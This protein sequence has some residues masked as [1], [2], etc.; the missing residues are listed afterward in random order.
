MNFYLDWTC[1]DF[2]LH[3]IDIGLCSRAY[4][5]R[6]SPFVCK[7]LAVVL[8][9]NK[10]GKISLDRRIV[11][12]LTKSQIPCIVQ[13]ILHVHHVRICQKQSNFVCWVFFRSSTCTWIWSR[14]SLLASIWWF[15]RILILLI[16]H[17][18]FRIWTLKGKRRLHEFLAELGLVSTLYL[19][20]NLLSIKCIE[21]LDSTSKAM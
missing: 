3:Y 1:K 7:L 19:R 9:I 10:G 2:V 16:V 4:A 15:L 12:K 18:R 14:V 5:I 21:I 17:A 6:V 8:L 20:F 11:L 13:K